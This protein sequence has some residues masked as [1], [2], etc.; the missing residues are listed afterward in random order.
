MKIRILLADD[1]EIVRDGLRNILQKQPE[2]EIIA[3]VGDGREAIELVRET[4]INV[5]LMDINMPNLNGVEATRQIKAI[6]P[7]VKILTLSVHSQGPIIAQMIHA[8]ASGYLPKTCATEELVEAIRTVMQDRTY[9]S[10][11]VLESVT[12][13]LC[14]DS[15]GSSSHNLTSRECEVLTLIA[16]GKTTKEIANHLHLSERTVEFHR[17]NIMDKLDIHNIAELT[18]YAVREGLASLDNV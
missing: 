13:Y 14:K 2:F 9:I 6:S 10:P 12:E 17:H 15:K 1:H 8:G 16:N 5:I 11:K 7:D 3:C 18:K 4:D